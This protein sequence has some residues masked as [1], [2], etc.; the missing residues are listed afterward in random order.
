MSGRLPIKVRNL[1]CIDIL[2]S[3]V[4]ATSDSRVA[5]HR[6][7]LYLLMGKRDRISRKI[8]KLHGFLGIDYCV[9]FLT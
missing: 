6:L 3:L 7:E 1:G 5:D 9:L 4:F 8:A 2:I